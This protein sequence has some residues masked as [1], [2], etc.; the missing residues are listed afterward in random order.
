MQPGNALPALR[1]GKAAASSSHV[2]GIA[3]LVYALLEGVEAVGLWL[4]ERW[5]E[6]LTFIVST[7]LIPLEIYEIIQ[8][9]TALKVLGFLINLAVAAYLI[10]AKRLFGVRGGGKVDEDLR[11]RDTGWEPLERATPP[12]F[13]AAT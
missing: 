6:Y 11:A 12:P 2:L 13:E 3:L 9:G 10:V 5:A 7:L 1:N 8:G 4:T